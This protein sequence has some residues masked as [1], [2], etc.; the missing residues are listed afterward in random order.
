MEEEEKISKKK[1][2]VKETEALLRLSGGDARKLF[3][4]FELAVQSDG[5]Q[6][7]LKLQMRKF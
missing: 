3:N 4:A 6:K 7:L 1:I 2:I 5:S